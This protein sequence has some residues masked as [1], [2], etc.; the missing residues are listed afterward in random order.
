MRTSEWEERAYVRGDDVAVTYG[1]FGQ[2]HGH[3]K[4]IKY[5]IIMGLGAMPCIGEE[6]S[7]S[8]VVVVSS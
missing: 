4:V 6:H 2:T 3:Q 1:M 7:T 5:C 8:T